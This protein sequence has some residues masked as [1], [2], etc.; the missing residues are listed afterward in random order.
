MHGRKLPTN[1]G[2]NGAWQRREVEYQ[3]EAV[4]IS[5]ARLAELRGAHVHRC[6]ARPQLARSQ[7]NIEVLADSGTLSLKRSGRRRRNKELVG[8]R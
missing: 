7:R 3:A 8:M 6:D 2:D 5:E 1:Y 4:N